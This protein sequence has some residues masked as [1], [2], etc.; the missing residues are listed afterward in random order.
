MSND[1][2]PF[3]LSCDVTILKVP[4]LIALLTLGILSGVAEAGV[5]S[6]YGR[7]RLRAARGSITFNALYDQ[8]TIGDSF[9]EIR[10]ASQGGNGFQGGRT[11]AVVGSNFD[12]TTAISEKFIR[13]SA[14]AWSDDGGGFAPSGAAYAEGNWRDAIFL[15]NQN[16]AAPSE[17]VVDFNVTGQFVKQGSVGGS[18]TFGKMVFDVL[19]DTEVFAANSLSRI[20]SNFRFPRNFVS[21]VNVKSN[22]PAGALWYG[23]DTLASQA[24]WDRVVF[25]GSP[26][27]AVQNFPNVANFWATKTVTLPYDANIGGYDFQTWS[28]ALSQVVGR[29]GFLDTDFSNSFGI[30]EVR[31][32]DGTVLTDADIRFDSGFTLT[33]N[34]A[35][36]EPSS[37][38]VV[39]AGLI[40]T[41][42]LG[43][44]R[45]RRKNEPKQ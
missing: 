19:T 6:D 23:G 39:A 37:L 41:T 17:I 29:T 36:P 44:Q 12:G 7:A 45:R 25:D 4:I 15:R 27:L 43:S 22:S 42:I 16:E 35:V 20:E 26:E 8:V 1:Q 9:S 13:L 14:F 5:I 38:A 11:V 31:L 18:T 21:P 40:G 33:A 28:V 2:L 24:G 3:K 10:Q 30:S 32:T 34:Q